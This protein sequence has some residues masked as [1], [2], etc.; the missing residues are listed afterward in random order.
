MVE[1]VCT[2]FNNLNWHDS[3]LLGIELLRRQ[4]TDYLR[5]RLKLLW[6]SRPGQYRWKDATLTFQD[7]TILKLDLDLAGKRVCADDIAGARCTW[8][9]AL[10]DQLEREQ[11]QHEKAPLAQFLHFTISLIPPGGSID[12]FAKEFELL[13]EPGEI[14]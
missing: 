3:K 5:C 7:C 6:D 11:L 10:K 8:Q 4:G 12:V 1:D 9:S 2:R 13:I 14:S